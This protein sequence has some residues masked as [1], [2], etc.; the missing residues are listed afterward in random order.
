VV[1]VAGL[2]TKAGITDWTVVVVGLTT[3]RGLS[4]GG[5]TT[6]ENQGGIG[7]TD[8]QDKGL[9]GVLMD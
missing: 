7:W 9:S 8:N 5:G 6:T 4:G 2:T 3:W 1:V